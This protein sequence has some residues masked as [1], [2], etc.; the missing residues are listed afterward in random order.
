MP[1]P[2]RQLSPD[3]NNIIEREVNEFDAYSTIFKPELADAAS[4]F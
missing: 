3:W 2:Q 1:E 4:V